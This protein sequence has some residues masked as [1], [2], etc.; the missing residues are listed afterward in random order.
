MEDCDES[1]WAEVQGIITDSAEAAGFE[2]NIVSRAD[3]VGVIHKRIIQNLYDNPIVVCDVSYKNPNVMFELGMR[4][5][6]DKPTIII[7]DDKTSYN[8][9]TSAIEHLEYPRDLRYNQIL[10]FKKLLTEK[11]KATYEIHEKDKNYTTFLKHFGEFKV[12]KIDQKEVSGEEYIIE[13]L[14]TLR[15]T[16]NR[17]DYN[18]SVNYHRHG[19][20]KKTTLYDHDIDI[21]LKDRDNLEAIDKCT[22]HPAL[23]NAKVLEISPNHYHFVGDLK[24]NV[25]PAQKQMIE[26]EVE[27]ILKYA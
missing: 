10:D 13:E 3:E 22:T 5:A 9:D 16:I 7:K 19:I 12:A 17:L 11:I 15:K 20:N 1:H 6:F 4:L 27:R 8:F 25:H 18:R 23:K 21:C 26:G 2:A 24:A 14:R